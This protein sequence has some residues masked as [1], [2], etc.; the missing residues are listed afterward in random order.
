MASPCVGDLVVCLLF[1]RWLPL[2]GLSP[3]FG[4]SPIFGLSPMFHWL[5]FMLLLHMFVASEM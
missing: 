3:M 5:H 1:S 2:F 4:L